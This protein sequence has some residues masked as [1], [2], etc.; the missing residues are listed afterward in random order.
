MTFAVSVTALRSTE[1]TRE[2][3]ETL[4]GNTARPAAGNYMN[5]FALQ[6][7]IFGRKGMITPSGRAAFFV[8]RSRRARIKKPGEAGFFLYLQRAE[9]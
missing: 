1:P 9:A 6:G 2:A 7:A 3:C 4:C 8:A 5:L